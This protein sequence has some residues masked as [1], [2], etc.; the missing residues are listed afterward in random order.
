MIIKA[1]SSKDLIV[2][3]CMVLKIRYTGY[4]IIK[5]VYKKIP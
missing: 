2:I 4:Y 1:F 5:T 3:N